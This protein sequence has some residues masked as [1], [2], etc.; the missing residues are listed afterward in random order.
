MQCLNVGQLLCCLALLHNFSLNWLSLV[1]VKK[2]G[3]KNY[4][5]LNNLNRM[6]ELRKFYLLQLAYSPLLSLSKWALHVWSTYCLLIFFSSVMAISILTMSCQMQFFIL[7]LLTVDF[8]VEQFSSFNQL[9]FWLHGWQVVPNVDPEG[10]QIM[11]L[12][13]TVSSSISSLTEW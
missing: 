6:Q 10:L 7:L 2:C 1:K 4:C 13:G 11:P 12:P 8:C 9:Q 5:I 3:I